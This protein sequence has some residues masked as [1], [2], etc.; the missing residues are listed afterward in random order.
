M[1]K[2]RQMKLDL[3]WFLFFLMINF[4]PVIEH[5]IF[6]QLFLLLSHLKSFILRQI[7]QSFSFNFTFPFNF[8]LLS[9]ISNSLF[10]LWHFL[11]QGRVFLQYDFNILLLLLFYQLSSFCSQVF[12]GP[13]FLLLRLH[14]HLL[15]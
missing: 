11:R 8:H 4:I 2:L 14:V 15:L 13:P 7:H 3:L 1:S 12:L 6:F 10:L 9:D 5:F